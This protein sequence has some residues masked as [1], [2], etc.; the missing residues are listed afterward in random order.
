MR[1]PMSTE[2][3]T[4]KSARNMAVG[5]TTQAIQ[6]LLSFA[7]RGIF[8]TEL[9]VELVGVNAL[10]LSILAVLGVTDLG[11]NGALMFALYKPLSVGDSDRVQNS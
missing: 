5:L 3:R 6:V 10:L 11:L 2:T 8:V 1:S 9:G 4:V 7:A